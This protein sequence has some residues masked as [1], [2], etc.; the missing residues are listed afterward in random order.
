VEG[1]S[2]K[3]IVYH[4]KGGA[5]SEEKGAEASMTGRRGGEQCLQ[6]DQNF[7]KRRKRGSQKPGHWKHKHE[8]NG[9][10]ISIVGNKYVLKV[11]VLSALKKAASNC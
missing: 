11:A 2:P 10:K 5:L 6:T 4:P 1:V 7:I 8:G 3:G 9:M